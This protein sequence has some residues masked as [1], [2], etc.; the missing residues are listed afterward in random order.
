M[1]SLLPP[2]T[3][4]DLPAPW[5]RPAIT[6]TH[7]TP[8]ASWARRW[9]RLT[10][11]RLAADAGAVAVACLFVVAVRFVWAVADVLGVVP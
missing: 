2:D 1:N 10:S 5:L 9:R 8:R 11:S 7:T 3:T 6:R 4:Q